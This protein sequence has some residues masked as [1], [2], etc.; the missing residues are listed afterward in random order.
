VNVQSNRSRT[1]YAEGIAE[2][3]RLTYEFIDYSLHL[4]SEVRHHLRGC[5]RMRRVGLPRRDFRAGRSRRARVPLVKE[6]R[7]EPIAIFDREGGD[8]FLAC[9]FG[10]SRITSRC[11]TTSSCATLDSSGEQW[12]T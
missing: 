10:R 11:R 3:A 7:L 8:H 2:K 9:R 1:D 5:C 6:F 12:P 4:Y